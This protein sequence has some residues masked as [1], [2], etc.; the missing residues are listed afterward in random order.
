MNLKR[1]R[2]SKTNYHV[3]LE[4]LK[5]HTT[6][7]IIRKTSKNVI[8]QLVDYTPDSDKIITSVNTTEVSK[9]GWKGAKKNIPSSYLAGLLLGK[10][11]NKNNIQKAILDLGLHPP[12]KKSLLYA[13]LKGALDSGLEIPHSKEV[14]PS[15]DR[16]KGKH[17]SEFMKSD[18]KKSQHQFN[19]YKQ[20]GITS[21]NIIENFEQTKK[22]IMESQ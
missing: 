17:I 10:K 20:T 6:R 22:K 14:I 9:Y 13:A 15:E 16:I 12:I 21:E 18:S 8:L 19:K 7:M 1:K 11:A 2:E 4:L 5:S 3:R